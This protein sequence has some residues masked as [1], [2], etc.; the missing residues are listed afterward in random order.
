MYLF[1]PKGRPMPTS[2]EDAFTH[3]DLMVHVTCAGFTPRTGY[4][5]YI[6]HLDGKLE[7]VV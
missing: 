2:L 6:W 3:S 7:R 1:V 5:A 4:D